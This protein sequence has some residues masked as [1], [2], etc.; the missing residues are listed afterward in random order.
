M[1]LAVLIMSAIFVLLTFGLAYAIAHAQENIIQMAKLHTRT[2]K[3]WGGCILLA[4]GGWAILLAVFA[5]FFAT[6]FPV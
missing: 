5:D 2:V 3:R 1:I 4:I 6:L